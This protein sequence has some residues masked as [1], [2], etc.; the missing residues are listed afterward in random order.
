MP[1]ERFRRSQ[2][3][4]SPADFQRVY[5][6]RCSVADDVLIVYG[7]PNQREEGRLG[8]SVSKK[9]GGA[10]ERN[11]WKRVIRE[12]FRRQRSTA[13]G[14]DWIVLP[15]RGAACRF[16]AVAGSLPQL[17]KRLQRKLERQR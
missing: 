2:R 11:R 1:G 8:L 3:L 17:M 12:V 7:W 9:I 13:A 15:R 6:R 5:Q 4:R 10:V 14:V 16:E